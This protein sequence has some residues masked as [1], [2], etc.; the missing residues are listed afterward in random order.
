MSPLYTQRWEHIA[1]PLSAQSVLV[2]AVSLPFIS[3]AISIVQAVKHE[4]STQCWANVGPP[5]MTL[6]QH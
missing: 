4:T 5:S 1:L 3:P 2:C 6:T